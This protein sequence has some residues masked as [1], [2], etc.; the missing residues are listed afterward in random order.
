MGSKYKGVLFEL[1]KRLE[2][3]AKAS[4]DG[5]LDGI[6]WKG[7]SDDST[8]SSNGIKSNAASVASLLKIREMGIE[9]AI[10]I[11]DFLTRAERH[12]RRSIQFLRYEYLHEGTKVQ[13][14]AYFGIHKDHYK[15]MV[16]SGLYSLLMQ[17]QIEG[18]E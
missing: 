10:V 13:K 15:A 8:P 2:F 7:A 5:L 6:G 14:A 17:I 16:D 1:D 12:N 9:D 18:K 11:D 3:W 4:K